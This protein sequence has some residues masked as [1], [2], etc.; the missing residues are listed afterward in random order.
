MRRPHCVG[1]CVGEIVQ[2]EWGGLD[3]SDSIV[4]KIARGSIKSLTKNTCSFTFCFI[5]SFC[6]PQTSSFSPH[7]FLSLPL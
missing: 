6:Q 7:H 5:A 1:C 4:T 2:V 3:E